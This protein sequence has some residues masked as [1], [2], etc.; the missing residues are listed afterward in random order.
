MLLIAQCLLEKEAKESV[1]AS[2]TC[3]GDSL[4]EGPSGELSGS[5]HRFPVIVRT[6]RCR[7]DVNV[8]RV[9]AERSR[10]H[11]IRYVTIQH[12]HACTNKRKDGG[13]L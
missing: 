12:P 10:F 6:P 3:L 9:E 4:D 11:C 13:A 5:V 2:S 7:V 8:M 1:S